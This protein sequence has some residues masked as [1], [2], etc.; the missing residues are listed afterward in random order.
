MELCPYVQRLISEFFCLLCAFV[1]SRPMLRTTWHSCVKVWMENVS[2]EEICMKNKNALW[3]SSFSAPRRGRKSTA[4]LRQTEITTFILFESI[5]FHTIKATFQGES[6]TF[7]RF[8]QRKRRPSLLSWHTVQFCGKI[9]ELFYS[10]TESWQGLNNLLDNRKMAGRVRIPDLYIPRR[11]RYS[12]L[13]SLYQTGVQA[14]LDVTGT[15]CL[16]LGDLGGGW[17]GGGGGKKCPDDI[18]DGGGRSGQERIPVK[19]AS[20]VCTSADA[21][22]GRLARCSPASHSS[23]RSVT[24]CPLR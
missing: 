10:T 23:S 5:K 24:W 8:T 6:T 18:L 19:R 21:A 11:S 15:V 1:P 13:F 12:E 9:K 14:Q 7:L 2:K 22:R 20:F 17:S 3:K 4:T 16:P